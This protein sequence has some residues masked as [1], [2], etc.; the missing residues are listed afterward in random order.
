[1]ITPDGKT[2]ADSMNS[3]ITTNIKHMGTASEFVRVKTGVY[4]LNSKYVKPHNEVAGTQNV[5]EREDT[6]FI[7]KGGEYLV[8]GRLILHGYNAS[9][10]G[11]DKG[12]DIVAIKDGKMY[13]IQVKTAN[14]SATGYSSRK[15]TF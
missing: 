1:M 9:M 15:C 11:V 3:Q 2:P 13:G 14:K 12:I 8:T 5:I 6:Q 10:M 4:G 7:G